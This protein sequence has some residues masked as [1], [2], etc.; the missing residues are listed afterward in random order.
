MLHGIDPR[1]TP[2]LLYCLARMGHGDE[3]VIADS[4]FPAASTARTTVQGHVLQYPGHTAG[5]VA[6]VITKLMPLDGFID[7]A[8]LRMQVDDAPD[9]MNGAH[10]EV[11]EVL[12]PH[13]PEGGVLSSIARPEFY[14]QAARAFAV[15]QC[16]EARAYG[17]FILRQGVVF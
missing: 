8:A 7:Y 2:E 1:T 15:V 5:E 3:I 10:K 12:T 13:L 16:S 14:V 11:W 17:C 4:N 6:D 9:E